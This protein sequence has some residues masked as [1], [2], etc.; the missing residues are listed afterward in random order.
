M[1]KLSCNF[2]IQ[3]NLTVDKNYEYMSCTIV[4]SVCM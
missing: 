3:L 4:V 2:I 1:R